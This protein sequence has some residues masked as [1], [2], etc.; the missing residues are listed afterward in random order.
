MSYS[1]MRSRHDSKAF[2]LR[3]M[4]VLGICRLCEPIAFMSIFPYIYYMIESFHITDND[5]QIAL[6]AGLVTSAF[7]MAECMSGPIWGRL[8]DRYGRKPILLIGL[9][10]TGLSMLIFGFSTN[11][12]TA[13]IARALGGLLNG[14]IGV[15]QTTVAEVVTNESHQAR[16]YSV[17]PFV[18][19]LGSIFGSTLGGGLADPVKNYPSLFNPGSIFETYPYLLTNLVCAAVAAMSFTV[20]FFFL[21]ETHEDKRDRLDPGLEIGKRIIRPFEKLAMSRLSSRK[22]D[23]SEESVDLMCE[24]DLPPDYSSTASSPILPPAQTSGLPPPAYQSIEGSPRSSH[25]LEEGLIEVNLPTKKDFSVS[26]AFTKQVVFNIVGFG[27]LAYHTIS[28]EQLLSVL[29]SMP[30]SHA[31]ASLPFKFTGG[32]ALSTK[33]IGAIL[34]VQGLIQMFATMVAFT[35][36]TRRLGFLTTYRMVVISYPLLYLIIPYLTLVPGYWRIP[37]VLLVIAWKVT[38]QAF[39]FPSSNIMLANLAPSNKVLGTLNGVASSAAS[40]SRAFGPTL[41]GMLQSAGLSIGVMGLPWWT[42]AIVAIAGAVLSIFMVEERCRTF[43]SEKK[44]VQPPSPTIQAQEVD[45]ALAAAESL[46]GFSESQLSTPGSPLLTRMSLDT[47]R[48]VR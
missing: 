45:P 15:I 23:F 16:A 7:A 17:L 18:W 36:V 27:I 12:Q 46:N 40:G 30:E 48:H 6:Y 10:G 4:V 35:P 42:S 34:V 37:V 21:E 47:R 22:P 13:L 31:P 41:S 24:E 9:A 5:K 39:A 43:Q 32:F 25:E 29:F 19:C 2:P 38:A 26:G 3:Q 8:S 14:N 20:G 33:S 1:G 28:A 11:L 44:I